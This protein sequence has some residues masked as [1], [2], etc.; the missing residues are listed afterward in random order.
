MKAAH[1]KASILIT[2]TL[3]TFESYVKAAHSKANGD[4]AIVSVWFE[5]YVKAA[6][7]KALLVSRCAK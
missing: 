6:H 2:S 4:F 5:S 1:S 3:H 7:S